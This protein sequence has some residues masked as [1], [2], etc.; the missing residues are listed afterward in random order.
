MDSYASKK[1][2]KHMSYPAGCQAIS[3]PP[4]ITAHREIVLCF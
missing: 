1:I 3:C 2:Q 4:A